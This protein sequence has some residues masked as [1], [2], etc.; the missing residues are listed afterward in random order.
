MIKK[1]LAILAV[2]ASFT[3]APTVAQEL[4]IGTNPEYPPFEFKDENN[5]LQ[6][7]DIDIM[8]ELC[9]IM[10]R[11]C[12]Y[13]ERS[14]D[15]LIPQ[16][17]QRRFDIIISSMDITEARAKQV[18][19]SDPYYLNYSIFVTKKENVDQLK[20]LNEEKIGVLSG[21]THQQYISNRYGDAAI[22][23]YPEYPSAINDLLIDRVNV[24]FGDGEAV[25]EYIKSNDSLTT[26][27]E[28]VTD[29]AYFGKGL[30]IAARPNNQA[31]IDEINAALKELKESSKYDEIYQKWFGDR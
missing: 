15:A 30:A 23:S 20:P 22:S 29:E 18:L 6:G 17:R 7:F 25:Y 4:R 31:I 2:A 5:E 24:V 11:E 21:S 8:N 26:Y 27:G 13:V 9:T 19:F 28:Q 1:T 10:D 3:L 14:F 12:T 16:L